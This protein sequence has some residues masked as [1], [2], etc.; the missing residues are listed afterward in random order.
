MFELL[1]PRNI[2][3]LQQEWELFFKELRFRHFLLAAE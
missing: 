3:S 1:G 2:I